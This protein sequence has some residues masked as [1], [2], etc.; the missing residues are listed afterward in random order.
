MG[1]DEQLGF[2]F[3][4][5]VL[6]AIIFLILIYA[7][8]FFIFRALFTVLTNNRKIGTLAGIIAVAILLLFALT[9]NGDRMCNMVKITVH[10]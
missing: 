10:P 5:C 9:S 3:I 8:V 7:I 4:L 2:V 1:L 6:I